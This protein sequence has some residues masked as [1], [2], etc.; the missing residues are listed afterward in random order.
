PDS[1]AK[2]I[3]PA[4]PSLATEFCLVAT[5]ARKFAMSEIVDLAS[6][7]S[8]SNA[9]A[10]GHRTAPSV[11]KGVRNSPSACESAE[12]LSIVEGTCVTSTAAQ[13]SARHTSARQVARKAGHLALR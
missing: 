7:L 10:V 3:S 9:D 6:R 5:F 2:T 13:A 8:Q 11:I 12:P 1:H 4:A